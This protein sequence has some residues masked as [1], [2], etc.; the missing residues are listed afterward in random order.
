[1]VRMDSARHTGLIFAFAASLHVFG[2]APAHKP[3]ELTYA[4]PDADVQTL[5]LAC[6]DTDPCAVYLE[7]SAATAE[8]HRIFISGDFHTSEATLA[9]VLLASNDGGAT[10]TEP[11]ERIKFAVLDQIRF[12]TD[13]GW[14]A[15]WLSHPMPRDPFFLLTSDSGASWR[16]RPVFEDSRMGSVDAFRFEGATGGRLLFKP[17]AGG[18]EIYETNTGGESWAPAQTST[19]SLV[20]E[21]EK[22]A[23]SSLRLRAD[24]RTKTYRLEAREGE[25]WA[26]IAAFFIAAG[27]CK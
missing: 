7:L 10:W 5:G 18:A 21:R 6:S 2:A 8:H 13:S 23:A 9:S 24:G 11:F 20:F 16:R 22:P 14:I 27:V 17:A 12:T 26:A 1:M 3:V 15:G 4:C 25:H 19:G